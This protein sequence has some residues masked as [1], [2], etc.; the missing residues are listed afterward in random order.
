MDRDIAVRKVMSLESLNHALESENKELHEQVAALESKEVCTAPHD[1]LTFEL[2]EGCPY[3]RIEKIFALVRTQANDEGL[4]FDAETAPEAY[5]QIALRELHAVVEGKTALDVLR[6]A[7]LLIVDDPNIN[8][9]SDADKEKFR[10]WYNE[11]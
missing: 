3:C 5:L 9:P 4:W 6:T 11:Q 1:D 7:G 10:K 8:S 2:L